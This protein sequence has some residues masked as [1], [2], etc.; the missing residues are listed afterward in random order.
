MKTDL[1]GISMEPGTTECRRCGDPLPDGPQKAVV[2]FSA[3]HNLRNAIVIAGTR[4]LICDF[5]ENAIDAGDIWCPGR[6]DVP[7]NG[8]WVWEGRIVYTTTPSSPN[9]PEE[10]DVDYDGTWREP[11]EAE[12]VAI[13]T[14]R[15]PWASPP[16]VLLP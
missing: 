6:G 12:W 3:I 16:E 7:D 11:T 4:H 8:I 15:N 10:F 13:Q 1:T 9:G 5:V 2:V 14:G